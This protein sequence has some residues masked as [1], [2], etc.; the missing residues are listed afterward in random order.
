M[1]DSSDWENS[2]VE[3]DA[4]Q[5]ETELLMLRVREGDSLALEAIFNRYYYR[6]VGFIRRYVDESD[7]ED[8]AQEVFM[9]VFQKIGQIQEAAAFERYLFQSAKNRSINWLKRK[10]RLREL[11]QIFWYAADTWK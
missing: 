5:M 10:I 11:M 4:P 8:V 1:R 9:S 3:A 7:V 2:P 6:V